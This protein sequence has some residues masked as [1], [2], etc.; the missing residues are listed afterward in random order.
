MKAPMPKDQLNQAPATTAAK[1]P[2][3]SHRYDDAFQRPAVENW[4]RSGKPGTPIARELGLSYPT[5]KEWKRRDHGDATPDRAGPEAHIRALTAE[6]ARGREPRDIL[7]KTRGIL[8][9]ASKNVTHA[10]KA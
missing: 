4:I 7:K 6:R 9:E 1:P 8:S 5:R 2:G 3:P 10:S